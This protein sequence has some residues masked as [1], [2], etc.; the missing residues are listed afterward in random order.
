MSDPAPQTIS[1]NDIG[2]RYVGALQHLG[3]LMVLTWAG[4]RVVT[5]AG[6]EEV[7]RSV[8]GLPSTPFRLNFESARAEAA[9]WNFKSS[10]GDIL[11]LNQVFLEDIRKICG[12]VSFNVAKQ[13]GNGDLASLAAEINAETG[14]VDIPARLK[15]LKERYSLSVPLE[16]QMQSLHALH[17]HFI[18]TGGVVPQ[19]GAV[20]LQL[21]VIQPPAEGQ[22][23]PR[24]ADY[25][26]TWNPGE[27]IA[28][29]RE[30]HAAVFTT[31]SIFLNSMLGSVQEFAK[32]F[33]L[34]EHPEPQ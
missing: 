16:P 29:S 3:D 30:E 26:R 6:Y 17:Y 10:L 14:S 28:V 12:L 22:K 18:H 5:E 1:L 24:L 20:T 8:A 4:T 21:K 2:R 33:G 25:Q 9:R 11:G 13:S 27:R 7:F 23:E 34:D 31:V 32:A 15:H 19:N